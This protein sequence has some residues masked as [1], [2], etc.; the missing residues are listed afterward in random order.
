MSGGSWDY[1]HSKIEYAADR[2]SRDEVPQ[3]RALGTLMARVAKAMYAIEWA[4]S[5]DTAQGSDLAAI[6]AALGPDAVERTLEEIERD[7]A[8]ATEQ[9]RQLIARH[10][11][12]TARR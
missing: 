9:A 6:E 7:I 11:E 3:R 4:D 5:G 2:L 12:I 8:T 10:R 1:L